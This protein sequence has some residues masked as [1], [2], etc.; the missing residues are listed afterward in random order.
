MVR[1]LREGT[2]GLVEIPKHD[3]DAARQQTLTALEQRAPVIFQAALASGSFAGYADFLILDSCGRF[4][5]WDSKLARSVKPY[6]AVQLC[7][8]AELLADTGQAMHER[9]GIILGTGE[10]MGL[11]VEDF[12]RYYRHLRGSFRD[13]QGGFTGQLRAL[14]QTGTI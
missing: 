11:R 14:R 1:Q 10:R 5:V 8:Y 6:Y 4:Q 12:I 3:F 2:P 13:L 7:C 9:I